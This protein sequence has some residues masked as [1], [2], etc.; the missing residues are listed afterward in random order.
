MN[1]KEQT[2]QY[3]T[4]GVQKNAEDKVFNLYTI[5]DNDRKI[6][7][8]IDQLIE[9]YMENEFK[10]NDSFNA[11][12]NDLWKERLAFPSYMRTEELQTSVTTTLTKAELKEDILNNT[13]KY[14]DCAIFDTISMVDKAR[15][16]AKE[17]IEDAIIIDVFRVLDNTE[18]CLNLKDFIDQAKVDKFI[19]NTMEKSISQA[20]VINKNMSIDNRIKAVQSVKAD[21]K[22]EK[23]APTFDYER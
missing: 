7:G 3:G 6:T 1:Y 11:L 14:K 13:N 4:Y 21:A 12:L 15:D 22:K 5:T 20:K 16:F 18:K 9:V 17:N 8:T 10:F 2:N 23:T 19:E